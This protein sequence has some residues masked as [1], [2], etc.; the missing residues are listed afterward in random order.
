MAKSLE[1]TKSA[2]KLRTEAKSGVL[3]LRI[4]VKKHVLPFE[5]RMLNSDEYIFV[6]IPPSA[7]IMKLT[8]DGLQVVT[9]DNEAEAA[10]KSFRKSR[11]RGGGRGSRSAAVPEN[12]QQILE[13][14]PAG[15]KIGY[16]ADGSVKLVKSRRRRRNG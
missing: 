3:T 9:S 8:G 10:A 15:Y 4:G 7:E 6:H 1:K 13:Q 12:V 11:R 16:N 5:V 2:L 14:I